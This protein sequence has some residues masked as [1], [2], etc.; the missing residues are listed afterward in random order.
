MNNKGFLLGEETLKIVIAVICIG[1]LIYFLGALYFNSLGEEDL[2]LAKSSVEHIIEEL[3][4]GSTEIEIYNP[5]GWW[6][7]NEQNKICIC[8]KSDSCD[9]EGCI[10]SEIFVSG[11]IQIKNSPIVLEL[12]NGVLE[13]K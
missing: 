5:E 2:K 13:L 8:E 1:F 12:N 7:R 11:N 3:N 6:I 10:E 4:A 9:S